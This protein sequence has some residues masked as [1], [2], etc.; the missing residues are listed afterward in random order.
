MAANTEM[1]LLPVDSRPTLGTTRGGDNLV[2]APPEPNLWR[3]W[4]QEKVSILAGDVMSFLVFVYCLMFVYI[5]SASSFWYFLL[6]LVVAMVAWRRL[7]L[8]YPLHP[9]GIPYSVGYVKDGDREMFLVATL[10]ISPQSPRDVWATVE[11]VNPDCTMIEL[12]EERLNRMRAPPVDVER[13]LVPNPLDLQ[14]VVVTRPGGADE[15]LGQRAYWNAEWAGDTVSGE[16]VYDPDNPFG[17]MPTAG[18]AN[19]IALVERLTPQE[20]WA[21]FALRAEVA[22]KQGAKGVVVINGPGR[23][24]LGRLGGSAIE[25]DLKIWRQTRRCGF[26]PVP[27][28][29]VPQ[30]EGEKIKQQ[31]LDAPAGAIVA[32]IQIKDDVVPRRT[33]RRRVCQACA[34]LLSGIGILYGIIGCCQVDVGVEFLAAEEAAKARRIPCLCIDV[35]LN[36]F[37]VRILAVV[38]PYPS[39]ILNALW[40][41]L[42]FPRVAFQFFFPPRTYVDTFGSMF[43][44]VAAFPLRTWAAFGAAGLAASMV[45]GTILSLL[46]SGVTQV[47]ESTGVVDESSSM[48]FQL[49]L[50]ALVE[51]Y[52]LP[53][54]YTGVAACRDEVMYQQVVT[55]NR[56]HGLKRSVVVVGAGHAN[57]ILQRAR[58]RGLN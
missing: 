57:G 15:L 36:S 14:P 24:P 12:D 37:W 10:H 53:Q 34:L 35:D 19:K 8:K 46:A 31:C 47:G 50:T 28:V 22:W 54:I 39:N 5:P 4:T 52:A 41:W 20:I 1:G 13:P 25:T 43:R 32:S 26:P 56:K 23:L 21:P 38:V 49:Y 33:L 27:V 7:R 6:G 16:M 40:C 3:D 9:L 58:D 11:A 51:F 29:L 2:D 17:L 18:M 48:D 30:E 42:S 55:R 44:L 45:T